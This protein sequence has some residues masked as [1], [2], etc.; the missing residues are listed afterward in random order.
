MSPPSIFVHLYQP[1]KKKGNKCVMP[2][3]MRVCKPYR[4]WINYL[5]LRLSAFRL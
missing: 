1:K 4:S 3:H 2:P 5:M